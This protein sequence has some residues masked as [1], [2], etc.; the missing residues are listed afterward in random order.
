MGIGAMIAVAIIVISVPL[1]MSFAEEMHY[2]IE[3]NEGGFYTLVENEDEVTVQI[4]NT[5]S[6]TTINGKEYDIYK[7]G[8]YLVSDFALMGFVPQGAG[9]HTIFTEDKTFK[10]DVGTT[11]KQLTLT[12]A[13]GTATVTDGANTYTGEYSYLIHYSGGFGNYIY[14][15]N[16]SNNNVNKDSTIFIVKNGGIYTE[17]AI[18]GPFEPGKLNGSGSLYTIGENNVPVGSTT[19]FNWTLTDNGNKSYKMTGITYGS[20]TAVSSGIIPVKYQVYDEHSMTA[21]LVEMSPLMLGI[22]LMIVMGLFLV[23]SK[24]E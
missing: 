14:T 16:I 1:T 5:D 11:P 2:S 17:T 13:D 19:S 23:R 10:I 3:R 22:S 4:D 6:T 15:D 20:E 18:G 7:Y 8:C 9:Y 21:T 12:F 24:M